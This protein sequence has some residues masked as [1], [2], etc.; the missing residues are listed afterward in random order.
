MGI[1]DLCGGVAE[2]KIRIGCDSF[3]EVLRDQIV[4]A[5]IRRSSHGL[6]ARHRRRRTIQLAAAYGD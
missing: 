1:V 5:E 3:L 6:T 2:F 4:Q